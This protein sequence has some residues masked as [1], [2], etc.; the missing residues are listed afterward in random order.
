MHHIYLEL[1]QFNFSACLVHRCVDKHSLR[2]YE[3]E[4]QAQSNF[5][6]VVKS[7]H[8]LRG[9]ENGKPKYGTITE[10]ASPV[11]LA[12]DSLHLFNVS[13]SH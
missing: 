8:G 11:S 5:H 4:E 13:S 10:Q 2:F 6:S 12:L 1:F 7:Y 9:E 3:V